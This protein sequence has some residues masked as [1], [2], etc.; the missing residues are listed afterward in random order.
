MKVLIT[1]GGTKIKIDL[2]RS[3]TNMSR[4]TF[5][6]RICDAFWRDLTRNGLQTPDDYDRKDITFF[7]A[8][9]SRMP[10]A[11]DSANEMFEAGIHKIRYIEYQTFDEYRD[12]LKKLV[13]T[14]RFDVIVLAAAVSDYGVVN[15]FNGKYR[16]SSDDM[17]IRLVKLPKVI[18]EIKEIVPPSTLVCGFKLLVN[19]TD[20]E[21]RSAMK[22]QFDHGIDMVVGNDL[23][24]IKADN[25]RLTIKTRFDKEYKVY[26]KQDCDLPKTV[27]E[28][29]VKA[30]K[31][32]N[33]F[34]EK[35]VSEDALIEV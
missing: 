22:S 6:A 30:W 35:Q 26:T 32:K 29:C 28:T 33:G 8:K 23:R 15:V 34:F 9:D 3:I 31:Q 24:D 12:Q 27:V 10:T 20:D 25:H 5:G 21:L 13:Q 11:E 4:G 2:V 7:Y 19:S 1:S 17:T 14:E 16:S 18:D